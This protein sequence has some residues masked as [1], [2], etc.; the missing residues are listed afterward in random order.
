M[1]QH[2]EIQEL[3]LELLEAIGH[4]LDLQSNCVSILSALLGCLQCKFGA[5]WIF[6]HAIR[7]NGGNNLELVSALPKIDHHLKSIP[8]AHPIVTELSKVD[9]LTYD[10]NH[11]NLS[12]FRQPKLTRSGT[13]FFFK[14][15]KLG[16]IHLICEKSEITDLKT[17][18]LVDVFTKFA[19]AAHGSISFQKLHLEHSA[20]LKAQ[21]A[22]EATE[23][24][25]RFVVEGLSEG[26]IITDLEG[27]I[28]F[29]N[30]KM[31]SLSGYTQEELIGKNAAK[32]LL[33]NTD[34]ENKSQRLSSKIIDDMEEFLIEQR[35]KSGKVWIA[36]IKESPYR[37]AANQIIGRLGLVMDVTESKRAEAEL[38]AAK[39]VA[40]KAQRAEQQFLANMSHEIRTP[41]NAVIG[42]TDLLYNTELTEEQKDFVD[43]LKFS[44]D[45]L[46]GVINSILDLSKIEAGKLEF[47]KRPID[48][49]KMLRGIRQ[50]FHFK[51]LD[52]DI[53]VLMILDEQIDSQII[54]DPTRLNQV[55][56]NLMGNAAKF[57]HEGFIKLR[58]KLLKKK[59]TSYIIL[60]EVIDSG[61][62]IETEKVKLIFENFKQANNEVTRKY[63]GTG[64]G[65]AIVKQI[66]ELQNGKIEVISEKGK[67]ST[68]KVTLEFPFAK[69]RP[70]IE[71]NSGLQLKKIDQLIHQSRFLIVEDNLM[72][73]KL[74][75]R[76]MKM[77]S[78]NFDL[79]I[80]GLDAVAKS[81]EKKYNLIFMD[82]NMPELDGY[83]AT[84]TI[85][86]DQLNVN[87]DSTII[88]LTA[89]ALLNEKT[90]AI[91]AGMN[92]FV[93]KPFNAKDLKSKIGVWLSQ[94]ELSNKEILPSIPQTTVKGVPIDKIP[95]IDLTYLND[96]SNGDES[97]VIEMLDIFVIQIPETILDLKVQLT[98][99]NW[100]L[101]AD[102]AHKLKT[103]FMMIGIRKQK[104]DVI[105]LEK[106]IRTNEIEEEKITFLINQIIDKTNLVIPV[107]KET[108]HKLRK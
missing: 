13:N 90:K 33:L 86:K 89:S 59:E 34:N 31:K 48:L 70:I 80:D 19:I 88:A 79:A 44:A 94:Q 11:T 42:M 35:H 47:E 32:I 64:L 9:Y 22:L 29:V 50:T 96:M 72:N 107:L 92:D 37:S 3:K 39:H 84:K 87:K 91:E 7:P 62:G 25:Y 30:D 73:Q 83:E 66:V 98:D 18:I 24:K 106:M 36:R 41:M 68:F 101:I 99:K 58:V 14:L 71:S 105:E 108:I 21:Q 45:S 4:S 78:A 17:E 2:K 12:T 97:F 103:N 104:E 57:T 65:L 43:T 6:E 77:W 82:I 23:Q 51:L 69:E 75:T 27:R 10:A 28:V 81:K 100:K 49:K 8:S 40:I 56:T 1:P 102:L 55:L 74:I 63:G 54:G 20:K 76:I 53:D 52:K 85:R 93:T 67:G 5:V 60:F 38:K 16:L 61:I 46:M 95:Q 26:I 15:K